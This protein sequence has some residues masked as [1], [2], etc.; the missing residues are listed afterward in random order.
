MIHHLDGGGDRNISK[1]ALAAFLRT[2]KGRRKLLIMGINDESAIGALA[3]LAAPS[4][5][6]DSAVI[7]H[8]GSKEILKF[9]ADRKSPCIGT[10]SFHAERYGPDLLSFALPIVQGKSAPVYHYVPHEF[11]G[12]N[13]VR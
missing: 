2:L 9:I 7:G 8:G 10:V 12:K 1:S 11:I 4:H 13:S 6:V 3:A 5:T